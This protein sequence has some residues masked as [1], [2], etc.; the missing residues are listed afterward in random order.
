MRGILKTVLFFPHISSIVQHESVC[1]RVAYV[2]VLAVFWFLLKSVGN[3]SA[4]QRFYIFC[5]A[6]KRKVNGHG[7]VFRVHYHGLSVLTSLGCLSSS[8]GLICNLL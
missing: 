5:A 6:L 4:L 3:S 1:A 7:G 2:C 8:R